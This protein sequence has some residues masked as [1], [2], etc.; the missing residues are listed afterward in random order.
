MKYTITDVYNWMMEQPDERPLDMLTGNL[1]KNSCG[2][3]LSEFLK[4]NGKGFLWYIVDCKGNVFRHFFK[5]LNVID[6]SGANIFHY[7]EGGARNFKEAKERFVTHY[8]P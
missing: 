8:L 1:D 2:C 6:L 7:L 4:D 5:P 3:L